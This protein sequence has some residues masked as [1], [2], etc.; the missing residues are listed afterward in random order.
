MEKVLF[1]QAVPVDGGAV[2]DDLYSNQEDVFVGLDEVRRG[3]SVRVV[4]DTAR[5]KTAPSSASPLGAAAVV[6]VEV[7]VVGAEESSALVPECPNAGPAASHVS[8]SA[9]LSGW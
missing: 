6:D 4:G 2:K 3:V 8:M 7:G 5:L 1:L 9:T